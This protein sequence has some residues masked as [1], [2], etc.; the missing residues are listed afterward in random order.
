MEKLKKYVKIIANVP[1]ENKKP[2]ARE[3]IFLQ[4]RAEKFHAAKPVAFSLHFFQRDQNHHSNLTAKII[5]MWTYPTRK[6]ATQ[7]NSIQFKRPIEKQYSS[8]R[9][10]TTG[11][12]Y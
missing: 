8:S 1:H 2:L 12:L 3:Q 5:K 4:I 7:Y 11:A 10:K 6:E 9:R